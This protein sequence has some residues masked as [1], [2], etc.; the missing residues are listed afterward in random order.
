MRVTFR[1]AALGESFVKLAR[2]GFNSLRLHHALIAQLVERR[3]FNPGVGGSSPSGRTI[4]MWL[5]L[6]EHL[7]WDQGVGGSNPLIQTMRL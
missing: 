4:W 5:N 1:L 2:R 3:T 7:A 6:V